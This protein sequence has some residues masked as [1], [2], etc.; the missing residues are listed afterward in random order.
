MICDIAKQES[1]SFSRL[2]QKADKKSRDGDASAAFA[3]A[4]VGAS[5]FWHKT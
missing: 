5:E 3:T 1:R 2:A 4:F